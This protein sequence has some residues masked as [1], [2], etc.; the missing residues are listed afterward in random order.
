MN[1]Y[2]KLVKLFVCVYFSPVG[3]KLN[4]RVFVSLHLAV[5]LSVSS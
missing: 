5:G 2:L 1:K 3:Q 4:L